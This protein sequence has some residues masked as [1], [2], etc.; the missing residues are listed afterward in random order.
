[1]LQ[2][3]AFRPGLPVT[4]SCAARAFRPGSVMGN[5]EAEYTP[6]VRDLLVGGMTLVDEVGDEGF[7]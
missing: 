1:M 2:S 6:E 4:N 7:E 3:R 5:A